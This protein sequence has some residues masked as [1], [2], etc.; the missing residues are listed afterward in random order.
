MLRF[1]TVSYSDEID[2]IDVIRETEQ[3]VYYMR[4]GVETRA[5]K[6]SETTN[7]WETKAEA[8]QFLIE[9]YSNKIISCRATI[10]KAEASIKRLQ[11]T[12]S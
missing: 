2:A 10:K 1:R 11:E 6:R 12:R 5:P 8:V 7:F 3:F 4:A 9:F